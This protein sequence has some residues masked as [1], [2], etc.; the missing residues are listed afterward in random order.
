ESSQPLRRTYIEIGMPIPIYQG[1]PG[2]VLLAFSSRELQEEILAGKLEQAT[3]RTITD[4]NKLRLELKRTRKNGYALSLEE[5]VPGISTVAVPVAN[6]T[7]TVIAS[8][9]VTG[10]SSRLSRKRLLG[11]VAPAAQAAHV[12]SVNLGY[13][14]DQLVAGSRAPA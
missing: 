7:G 1:A 11:F 5:R 10:P 8:L 14:G 13:G 4:P 2:K 6:H 3:P 9:S 12:I